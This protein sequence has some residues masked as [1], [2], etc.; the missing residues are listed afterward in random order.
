M[1]GGLSDLDEGIADGVVE[2]LGHV[3]TL[4]GG[5]GLARVDK[6]TPEKVAGD[7]GWV[8]VVENDAGVVAA[9]LEGE[10]LEVRGGRLDDLLA[11]RRRTGEHDLVDVRVGGHGGAHGTVACNDLEKVRRQDVVNHGSE[12]E[13]GQRGVLRGLDD[14]GVAHAQ[15][16]SELP[17][18][19]HHR[20]VPR[21][22][23]THDAERTVVDRRGDVVIDGGVV[24]GLEGGGG[25]Q[26]RGAGTY[27][28]AGVGTVERLALLTGQELGEGLGGGLDGIGSFEQELAPLLILEGSEVFLGNARGRNGVVEVRGGADGVGADELAGRRVVDR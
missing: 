18:G 11:G 25:T 8:C 23:G 24:G 1:G 13:D 6:R 17:R 10:A 27:L 12:G 7:G 5:T 22:D 20:P 16:R 19:D 15:S 21:T 9:E 28:K 3:E 4:H 14:D 2:G 26:P